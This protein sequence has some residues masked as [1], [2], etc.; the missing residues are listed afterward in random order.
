[1]PQGEEQVYSL[2]K[3]DTLQLAAGRFIDYR[4]AP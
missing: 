2:L 3:L 4:A 1:L